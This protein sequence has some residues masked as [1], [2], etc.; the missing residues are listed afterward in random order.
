MSADWRDR[1]GKLLGNSAEEEAVAQS[2]GRYVNPP[3]ER[4]IEELG[5]RLVSNSRNKEFGYKFGIV[6]TDKPNAF[7]LPNGSLYVTLGLLRL[8]RTEA[9]LANVMGHEVSHVMARHSLKQLETNLGVT[10][11]ISLYNL[12]TKGGKDKESQQ[13]VFDV[14]TNG[15]SRSNESQADDLG[16]HLAFESGWDPQGMIDVMHIFSV[17]E[18]DSPRGVEAYTR[19]HPYATERIKLATD[20]MALFGGG[21]RDIGSERYESFLKTLGISTGEI[22][23]SPAETAPGFL[24]EEVSKTVQAATLASSPYFI[25]SLILTGALGVLLIAYFLKKKKD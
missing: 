19:S 6:K 9:Q 1:L 8:L 3:A 16:Q 13:F 4:Y 21:K 7:A 24:P 12:L 2:G 20:R 25:P 18:K 14:I 23:K 11:V 15:Y 22:K 5:Q 17:L 10:G